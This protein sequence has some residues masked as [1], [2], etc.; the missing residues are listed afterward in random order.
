MRIVVAMKAVPDL[1]EEIELT[2]DETG[3]DREYLK[4]VLNEWDDQALEEA[5]LVKDA[6]GA[7]VIAV[8]LAEDPDIEQAL[9]TAIAKGAD[10]AVKLSGGGLDTHARAA[11]FAAYLAEE[12]ADLVLTGVQ[13]PDDLDGQLAPMLAAR[14]GWRHVSVVVGVTVRDGNLVVRQEFSGGRSHELELPTPAVIGLQASRETPRYAP[15]TRI[16]QAMQAGGLREV[17]VGAAESPGLPV[18]RMYRPEQTGHA[19][20]FSGS[21][22]DVAGKIIELLRERG[23]VKA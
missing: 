7:E 23:I 10:G 13:A 15:I 14:L 9:Y 3:I 8:G 2:P 1:V 21:T 6:T 5:L 11:A 19:E 16:R 12:P 20:M 22:E 17:T 4:F 18:R